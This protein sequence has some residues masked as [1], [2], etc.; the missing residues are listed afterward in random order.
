MAQS[1]V[2]IHGMW[3]TAGNWQKVRQLLGARGYHCLVPSLPAHDARSDQPLQVR[4]QRLLGYLRHLEQVIAEQPFTRSPILIGH[5]MGAA[6]AEQLA[7]RVGAMAQVLLTPTMPAGFSASSLVALAPQFLLSSV[8]GVHKP[9]FEWARRYLFNGLAQERQRALYETLVHES[10]RGALELGL[11]RLAGADFASNRIASCPSYVVSCGR[12]RL[13]PAR[14][15][16]KLARRHV[17]AALRH[18]PQRGHWVI[19]DD[20]TEEMLHGICSWLR[21]FER[22]AE[23]AESVVSA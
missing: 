7:P 12:D 13:V 6:L 17:G 3:C 8:R 23:H 2:L 21:P 5:G 16:R 20:D 11:G 1:V 22:R 4:G 9:G 18:Y 10:V 15:G 19:D 14:V